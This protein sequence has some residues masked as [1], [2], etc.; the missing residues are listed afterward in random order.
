MRK[1][2]LFSVLFIL[3]LT[4]TFCIWTDETTSVSELVLDSYQTIYSGTLDI[5]DAEL[6]NGHELEAS[7][8]VFRNAFEKSFD[9]VNLGGYVDRTET[10]GIAMVEE[11]MKLHNEMITFRLI[12]YDLFKRLKSLVIENPL[13]IRKP[14]EDI[15]ERFAEHNVP[16]KRLPDRIIKSRGFFY[17]DEN[18]RKRHMNDYQYYYYPSKYITEKPVNV[19]DF[20]NIEIDPS[21]PLTNEMFMQVITHINDEFKL[22]VPYIIETVPGSTETYIRTCDL[23][24]NEE[25]TQKKI[26]GF[27]F[28]HGEE[29]ENENEALTRS[30]YKLY[31]VASCTAFISGSTIPGPPDQRLNDGLFFTDDHFRMEA[32]GTLEQCTLIAAASTFQPRPFIIRD[33]FDEITVQP[34]DLVYEKMV[35]AYKGL[36]NEVVEFANEAREKEYADYKMLKDFVVDLEQ[37]F[38]D[39]HFHDRRGL[40]E[41]ASINLQKRIASLYNTASE[42]GLAKTI[43]FENLEVILYKNPQLI[44]LLPSE[45]M[46]RFEKK[47]I[48]FQRI[49][50]MDAT[51]DATGTYWDARY[52]TSS[53]VDFIS[54][55][56]KME[57]ITTKTIDESTLK[58]SYHL[59]ELADHLSKLTF[60][61][62][63]E[64]TNDYFGFDNPY[65]VQINEEAT[66]TTVLLEQENLAGVH[67]FSSNNDAFNDFLNQAQM[68]FYSV[69][70]PDFIQYE[71]G[72]M[73][74][75]ELFKHYLWMYTTKHLQAIDNREPFLCSFILPVSG[76][77]PVEYTGLNLLNQ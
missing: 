46:S 5:I 26:K 13:F 10:K 43:F 4:S 48:T 40:V 25:Y 44:R 57:E 69:Q 49:P 7:L 34:R 72:V 68:S 67:L 38:S 24:N 52:I 21:V 56:E 29:V 63:I 71:D 18:G 31:E 53:A 51:N 73:A 12:D 65:A 74:F 22:P 20:L 61:S 59:V 50:A 54:F 36:Y 23:G 6:L 76:F 8:T 75:S 45:K 66:E 32:K 28:I 9:P 1:I 16:L 77:E 14:S 55:S 2:F 30:D 62:I 39:F 60:H 37:S 27:R 41:N 3:S 33:R 58:E 17:L 42:Q 35:E 19:K 47:G 11:I 64:M 70:E 15:T